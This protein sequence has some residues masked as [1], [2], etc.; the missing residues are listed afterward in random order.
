MSKI[1]FLV[2]KFSKERNSIVYSRQGWKDLIQRI[3]NNEL[4]ILHLNI[5]QSYEYK[6]EENERIYKILNRTLLCLPTREIIKSISIKLGSL[7][8]YSIITTHMMIIPWF[9]QRE[10]AHKRVTSN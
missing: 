9:I 8:Q 5:S 7:L 4:K 2:K 1:H 6:I 3:L 10:R